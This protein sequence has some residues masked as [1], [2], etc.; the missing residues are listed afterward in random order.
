MDY[1]KNTSEG[2][3]WKSRPTSISFKCKYSSFDNERF[4]IYIDLYA[5]DNKTLIATGSYESNNGE[6][7]TELT[8]YTITL[9]Y[10]DTSLKPAIIKIKCCSVAINYKPSVQKNVQVNVPEGSDKFY[11]IHGG[12]VLTLDDIALIYGR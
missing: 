7:I 12:S 4:G 2:R 9:D 6:S 10:R 1:H 3:E 11:N 5:E 8:D